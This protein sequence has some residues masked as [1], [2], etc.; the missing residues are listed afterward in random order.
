MLLYKHMRNAPK[1]NQAGMVSIMVTIIMMLIISLIVLGFSE[2]TRRNSREALDR[3]LSATAYY[4]AESGVDDAVSWLKVPANLSTALPATARTTCSGAGS[5]ISTLGNKNV[6]DTPTDT[7]YTCLL[8]DDQPPNLLQKNI[9]MGTNTI[10]KMASSDAANITSFTFTFS[11]DSSSTNTGTCDT[12]DQFR[13]A[14]TRCKFG[15]LRIDLANTNGTI[16]TAVPSQAAALAGLTKTLYIQ[17]ATSASPATIAAADTN[18]A[19]NFT[20]KVT[21]TTCTVTVTMPSNSNA[22]YGRFSM[23]YAGSDAINVSGTTTNGAMNFIG[24]QAIIDS[25]G[26]SVD[27]LRRLQVRVGLTPTNDSSL[28]INAVQSTQTICKHFQVSATITPITTC[29]P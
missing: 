19:Y 21:G 14:A 7:Q 17:P 18:S 15:V 20:C 16:S 22:Y 8:V 9:A 5:F 13:P 28:P 3:Q 6:L 26:K 23:M 29:E 24:G 11:Q 1:L 4:A 2:V 10:W 27:E 12:L 25:T